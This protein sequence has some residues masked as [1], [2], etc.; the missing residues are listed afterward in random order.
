M[1][2]IQD[3]IEELKEK[4]ERHNYLYYVLDNPEISDAE[5]DVLMRELL[6]L[7]SQHPELITPDSPT[8]RVGAPPLKEFGTITH[9][10]PMLSLENAMNE[11][12]IRAFDERVKRGLDSQDK[13]TYV[14][15]S[16]LDGL[17]VELIYE[18]GI[19]VSGSTRGDG[20]TGE[21]I[22][23]N[24]RTIRSIPLRLIQEQLPAPSLLEIRGEVFMEKAGFKTLNEQ[25]LKDEEPPFANP[26][27]AAAGS[28]RQLDSS[29][30]A[31]RP[32]KI[33]C[34]GL[35]QVEGATFMTH[36]KALIQL[37]KW[38]LPVNPHVHLCKGIEETIDYY[39]TWQE[40]R[41]EL[42][43]DIDG[44]VIKVNDFSKREQLGIRT[45]SPRWAIAGKF[46]AKQATTV[47]EDIEAS[48]GRTGAITP[49]AHL[50]P[51]NV[52][53]AV[54][55]RATLHNQDEIDRKD[56]RIG[57]TVLIQRAGDV[58]PEVIKVILSKRPPETKPFVLPDECP[59]CGDRV[60]RSKGE[61][62]IRCQNI[63]CPAQVKGRIEHFASKRAMK[64]EWLGTK[65][66][67]QM[68]DTELIHS[69]ADLYYLNKE[70]I[71]SLERMAEKSAGNIINSINTSRGT[72][73][74]QFIYGLGI[75]NV[76]EHLAQVLAQEFG[77]LDDLMSATYDQL[78]SIDEIGPIVADSIVNFFASHENR[79][80][81]QQCWDGGVKLEL[82]DLVERE[83]SSFFANKIFV[84]TGTLEKFTRYE[85]EDMV[86]RFGGRATKSISKK[87]DYVVAGPGA[88]SKLRKAQELGITTLTEEEFLEMAGEQ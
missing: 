29:I 2:S 3:R 19:F 75:R 38:G 62:V 26:R 43:Y 24:L 8:Q 13:V 11:S 78:H 73:L 25:R 56:I 5:Y 46:K 17:A 88:G 28:L 10:I 69:F 50:K 48:V 32:L 74:F 1:S 47:L 14:A 82:P 77:T 23:Q 49:V 79:R 84:F 34:Y 63:A 18:E 72:T 12:E 45:R 36:W 53:G 76:G 21:D 87:T 35:G 15:E 51:V 57:D 40:K 55:S 80:V 41:D 44:I 30:A 65:L 60:I 61:V 20:Y 37:K 83:T 54:V 16:K 31:K 7:D 68:V 71:L 52:G 85:A 33:Y 42:P 22:T 39:K 59:V 81:I 64:I 86:E 66:I 4:I 70:D 58:I 9:R 27:N 6:N 67:A